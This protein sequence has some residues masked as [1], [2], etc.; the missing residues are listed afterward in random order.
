MKQPEEEIEQAAIEQQIRAIQ[1]EIENNFS[2]SKMQVAERKKMLN[3]LIAQRQR[4]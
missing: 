2:L 1:S 4:K 3:K